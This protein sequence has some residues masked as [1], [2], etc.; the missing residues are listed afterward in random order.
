MCTN[1]SIVTENE[2]YSECNWANF[3]KGLD[4]GKAV[5]DTANLGYEN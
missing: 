3:I 1:A 5:A 4:F 2:G